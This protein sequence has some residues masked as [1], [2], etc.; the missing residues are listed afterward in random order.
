[1]MTDVRGVLSDRNDPNSVI[2]ELTTDRARKMIESGSVADGMIPKIEACLEALELGVQRCHII[3]GRLKHP[4]LMEL[5][6]DVGI[7]TMLQQEQPS[8][9]QSVQSEAEAVGDVVGHGIKAYLETLPRYTSL[10]QTLTQEI[11]SRGSSSPARVLS[12]MPATQIGELLMPFLVSAFVRDKA[13]PDANKEG[14]RV[15]PLPVLPKRRNSR[16]PLKD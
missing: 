7:G 9:D 6:T 16:R 3:D 10:I 12:K 5:F 1:M 13:I 15:G 4:L 14:E 11:S 8:K 2:A